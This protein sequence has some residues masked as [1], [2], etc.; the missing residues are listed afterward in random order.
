M[1]SHQTPEQRLA[2]ARWFQASSPGVYNVL[3]SDPPAKDSEE[4]YSFSDFLSVSMFDVTR[5]EAA[6][7][8]LV[9][10]NIGME[11]PTV[12]VPVAAIRRVLNEGQ[13]TDWLD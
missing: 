11:G 7:V 6:G 8:T 10:A 13:E 12:L 4:E 3:L 9:M 2:D 5:A 1:F